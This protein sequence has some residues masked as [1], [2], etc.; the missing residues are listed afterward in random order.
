VTMS[1]EFAGARASETEMG[2]GS[3][4]GDMGGEEEQ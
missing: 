4:F 1:G 2:G 3:M